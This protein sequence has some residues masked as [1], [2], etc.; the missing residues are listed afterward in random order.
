[1]LSGTAV[2]FSDVSGPD[3][4]RLTARAVQGG[5]C[6]GLDG[7]CQNKLTSTGASLAPWRSHIL[8][9]ALERSIG[10]L[11]L[12]R[13]F[14]GVRPGGVLSAL[15]GVA[16]LTRTNPKGVLSRAVKSTAI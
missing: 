12:Q 7:E 14:V 10:Q 9:D 15:R 3:R 16:W 5:R 1:M 13:E 11:V 2:T 4:L 6:A 8:S